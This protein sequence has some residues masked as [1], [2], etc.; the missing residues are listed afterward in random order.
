MKPVKRKNE[1]KKEKEGVANA[2]ADC[3]VVSC[4]EL[5]FLFEKEFGFTVDESFLEEAAINSIK[6]SVNRAK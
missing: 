4:A 3:L 1:I 2:D 6:K 5:V